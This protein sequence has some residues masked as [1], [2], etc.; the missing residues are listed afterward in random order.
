MAVLDTITHAS[1]VNPRGFDIDLVGNTAFLSN[2]GSN[3]ITAVDISDPSSLSIAG[4]LES[5]S[6]IGTGAF[7]K[8]LK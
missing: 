1:I 7:F 5:S 8:I 2:L 6:D 3:F 4:T